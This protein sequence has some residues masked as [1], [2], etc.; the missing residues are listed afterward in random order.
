M[1]QE[2]EKQSLLDPAVVL[3]EEMMIQIFSFVGGR[4]AQLVLNSGSQAIRPSF[5]LWQSQDEENPDDDDEDEWIE[6]EAA[7]DENENSKKIRNEKE[8]LFL[9]P[10]REA[11]QFYFQLARVCRGWKKIIDS[12]IRN[13]LGPLKV[14]LDD[15]SENENAT[16]SCW[17]VLPCLLWLCR[18]QL[19]IGTLC[20]IRNA[21]QLDLPLFAHVLKKCHTS[22]A[23]CLRIP[24]RFTNGSRLLSQG[25]S[26]ANFDNGN[27]FTSRMFQDTIAQECPSLKK[28]C[29]TL[30]INTSDTEQGYSSTISPSLFA[31]KS[32]QELQIVLELAESH[33]TYAVDRLFF[34]HLICKLPRLR[35]LYIACGSFELDHWVFHIKSNSLRQLLVPNF[36]KHACFSIDCPRLQLF[37][38]RG[39]FSGLGQAPEEQQL[40]VYQKVVD[41]VKAPAS[42]V[43]VVDSIGNV[44]RHPVGMRLRDFLADAD[45]LTT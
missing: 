44:S 35:F 11:A 27:P 1:V 25:S 32:I 10:V 2:N 6:E 42:C 41:I 17:R 5:S 33:T 21:T 22:M 14:D 31:L 39:Q 24:I 38:C 34:T 40:R 45:F 9:L 3:S 23:S 13:L 7:E 12:S 43:A 8:E 19:S 20:A 37:R 29:I 30:R 16:A 15:I 4:L 36:T 28:L 18:H 26:S